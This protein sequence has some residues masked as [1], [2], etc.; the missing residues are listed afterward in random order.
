MNEKREAGYHIILFD[1][2]HLTSGVYFCTIQAGNFQAIK[3]ML[4]IK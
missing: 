4:L 1:A 2:T 3:K